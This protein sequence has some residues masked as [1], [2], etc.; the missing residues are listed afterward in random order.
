MRS[1]IYVNR[2]IEVEYDAR[3][4][5]YVR[6]WSSTNINTYLQYV[7]FFTY[8]HLTKSNGFK[9]E[10]AALNSTLGGSSLPKDE[11]IPTTIPTA[12]IFTDVMI[13]VT[14]P[15]V[16][17]PVATHPP[18]SSTE[19]VLPPTPYSWPMIC[20]NKRESDKGYD[21]DGEMSPFYDAVYYEAPLLC[22][23]EAEVGT[24]LLEPAPEIPSPATVLTHYDI[25]K[26]KV[27]GLKEELK[28]RACSIKGVK[29]ELK[30]HLKEA[31][32]NNMPLVA[33]IDDAVMDDLAGDK[34]SLGEK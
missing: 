20:M 28:K 6:N 14:E 34:I 4:E 18:L 19:L 22:D 7:R 30:M 16:A 11:S 25:K 12:Y 21:I 27:L 15:V 9:M 3:S 23:N 5:S 2:D 26:L 17:S 8:F 24:N 1:K 33:N 29:E 31:V 13:Q 32:G 10:A